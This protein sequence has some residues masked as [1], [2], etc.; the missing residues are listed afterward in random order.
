ML[1]KTALLLVFLTAGLVDAVRL[2]AADRPVDFLRD[3]KPILSEHCWSC[4][5]GDKPEGGLRLTARETLLG[6]GESGEVAVV[7]EQPDQS[8]LVRRIRA[9]EAFERMPP[10]GEK[11][12]TAQQIETLQ[13]WIAE[14]ANW[15]R[16]WS[17][18]PLA[19]T[20]PPVVR[21]EAWV[22]NDLDRFILAKLE[23][24]GW[25]PSPAADRRTLIKRL[26]YD[27]L[28]LPP[29]PAEVEAFVNDASPRAYEDLVDR[30]LASPRFGE[31]WGRHWLDLAH[32]AD[33][34]GYEK[35]RARPDAYVYRDWVI[36]AINQDLPYDR[37]T[38]EQL[39][40]DLLPGST[41]RQKIATGFLR[42]TLTNEEGGVD[43]EEYRIAAAFD[44]TETIGTVWLALTI[45]CARCHTHKY[46][47]IPHEDFYRLFAFFNNSEEVTRPLPIAAADLAALEAELAPLE[48]ALAARHAELA[49]EAVAWATHEHQLILS[50]PEGNV[51]ELELAIDRVVSRSA[52]HTEFAH[53]KNAV[54]VPTIAPSAATE[55]SGAEPPAQAEPG[56][57]QTGPDKDTYTVTVTLGSEQQRLTGFKL[58]ALADERLPD[59]GPGRAPNGNFVLTGFRVSVVNADGTSTPIPLHRAEADFAQ[60][61]FPADAA[62]T[63]TS[64][65][66]KPTGWAIGGK[67]GANHWIQ[68]RTF[69]TWDLPAGTQLR[70][71]L[72]QDYGGGHTLGR[73][74]LAGLTGGERG[75][76]LPNK[77]IA[78]F[79]EMYPEKR[80]ASVKQKLFQYFV[81][82]VAR[83]QT[84]ADL[85]RRIAELHQ[86][87]HAKLMEI[88]TLGQPLLPRETFVFHRGDFLS[89]TTKVEPGVPTALVPPTTTPSNRLDLAQ[90]LV[91]PANPL[92]PRVAVNHAW[93]HLFGH[94]IVR[95]P[96]DFGLRGEPPTHPELLDWLAGRFQGDLAWSRKDLIRL[97]VQSATY[98][99]SSRFRPEE[100]EDQ[101]PANSLVF[102]QNRVRVEAEL[103]RDLHLAVSG[104]LSDKIGGPSVFPPMPEDLAKLSYANNF[105]WS[106]SKGEDRYRRGMY[107][108]FKRTIPHP[109]L[110]TFD[111]PDANVAC[112]RRAVSNTPLQALTMLNNET[113]VEAAQALARRL[114]RLPADETSEDDSPQALD[115]LRLD[116]GMRL[117]VARPATD[118]EREA[119]HRV[120]AAARDYYTQH[121]EQAQVAVGSYGEADVEPAESAAWTVVARTLLNLD[122]FVTRE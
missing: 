58:F 42:Q 122:E 78:G 29:A 60:K 54:F 81:G 112:V 13:R 84:A 68:F 63:T 96:D 111:A 119:L 114:L 12:L 33:S 41:G 118:V 100:L 39:A 67:A 55:P 89:P 105:S 37:F 69:E 104:L 99:Q 77:E 83:D 93:L 9:A 90:W 80:I 65:S 61:G 115:A 23:A 113:H 74:R 73:F 44:R 3:V 10:E 46:D 2:N 47:P 53:E 34:D 5:G 36:D 92:T 72:A 7:P 106:N 25:S 38:L 95:T 91:S 101:D 87:H 82:E 70:F 31:R 35:D 79:L 48:A 56:P 27:L 52:A 19:A 22:R 108:F 59:K 94:G 43:Q 51:R 71:E 110:M 16:H 109:N 85:A 66:D 18:E 24:Q 11:P 49:P 98:R 1:R 8:E 57:A 40:G 14:G 116:Y 97:I 86:Q 45:G 64:G 117:C 32:Y 76:Q 21:D 4:H 62:L 120:L 107:T 17:F 30:L 75:I 6:A 28:G 20:A 50:Q 15:D 103:I 88:R 102:R 121:A 26:S